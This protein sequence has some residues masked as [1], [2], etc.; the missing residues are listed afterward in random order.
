M[1]RIAG[2]EHRDFAGTPLEGDVMLVEV[3]VGIFVLTQIN[4]KNRSPTTRRVARLIVRRG[5]VRVAGGVKEQSVETGAGQKLKVLR[6][7]EW[8]GAGGFFQSVGSE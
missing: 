2:G 7:F 8:R 5:G 3:F 4:A 6:P 1:E